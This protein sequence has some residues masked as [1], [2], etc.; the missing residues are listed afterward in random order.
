LEIGL[1]DQCVI[2]LGGLGTRLGAVGKATPKPLLEVGGTPFVEV[3]IAEARRRGFRNFVLLAGHKSERVHAFLVERDIEKRFD[4]RV[5]L[6]VEPTPFGTGGALVHALPLLAEEF[7]LLNG[8]TWFDFNWRDLVA[9]ARSAGAMA[10]LSLRH[11]ERPDRYET[12]ARDGDRVAQ[13]HPRRHDLATATINGGVYYLTRRA[14]QDLACPSSLEADLLP[15]LVCQ[16][17]LFGYDYSGFF[18]DIGL[19]ETLSAADRLVPAERKRPAVFLDRDGVLNID[20]GYVH[21]P[22]E[23]DWVEGARETVKFFNDAGYFVFVVTNQAGVAKGHYEESAIGVLHGW[24]AEQLAEVGASIDDW[25][26]C[27]FHPEGSVA[28]YRAAHGWRKPNPGMIED[29]FAHWPIERDGSFLIGDKESDV[30]A[31]E[32]AGMPGHLFRG[33]D[34]MAFAGKIGLR[35]IAPAGEDK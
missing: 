6:S 33:G 7:L 28:A 15:N 18:I 22:G 31:A 11:V 19:P 13:I 12:V 32:A 23:I 30:Q 17:G 21:A 27:P 8:D 4:C 2:L 29:L 14:L 20:H 1:I 5:V 3:L 34:L 16:G 9:R 24:M 10:A 25:R 26:Y 35:A